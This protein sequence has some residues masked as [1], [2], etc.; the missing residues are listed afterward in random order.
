V[1]TRLRSEWDALKDEIPRARD[2]KRGVEEGG[3]EEEKEEEEEE[4]KRKKKIRKNKKANKEEREERREQSGLSRS[5]T[6]IGDIPFVLPSLLPSVFSLSCA[7]SL[8]FS[9]SHSRSWWR[10]SE[11]RTEGSLLFF[12]L[13]H[14]Q[15][16]SLPPCLPWCAIYNKQRSSFL[17][18]RAATCSS[19]LLASFAPCCVVAHLSEQKKKEASRTFL[20]SFAVPVPGQMRL[21]TAQN[22]MNPRP[23]QLVVV[24]ALTV[25][26]G[27]GGLDESSENGEIPGGPS[28]LPQN[29]GLNTL[30]H[31]CLLCPPWLLS[32][33]GHLHQCS[34]SDL[35]STNYSPVYYLP[36]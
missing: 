3:S 1:R 33:L 16:N 32:C 7:L 11:G 35:R 6:Q 28:Q 25:S 34:C 2:A 10:Q 21:A 8:P 22:Q 19:P 12:L 20:S 4:G 24:A 23:G 5:F 30:T 31:C 29:A 9:L 18:A 13:L 27:L 14:V 26:L 36:D 15:D 17:W